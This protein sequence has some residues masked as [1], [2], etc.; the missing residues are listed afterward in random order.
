[1]KGQA[2]LFHPYFY[3]IL[4]LCAKGPQVCIIVHHQVCIF[5]PPIHPS[6]ASVEASAVTFAPGFLNHCTP[7]ITLA[8]AGATIWRRVLLSPVASEHWDWPGMVSILMVSLRWLKPSPR[9]GAFFRFIFAFHTA[10]HSFTHKKASP[11]AARW[12]RSYSPLP[13]NAL[14]NK[15]FA[16]LL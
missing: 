5:S 15:V 4:Y 13:Q 14:R 9:A 12:C 3:F 10:T 11:S 1:V 16:Q 7:V 8:P 6:T 2:T